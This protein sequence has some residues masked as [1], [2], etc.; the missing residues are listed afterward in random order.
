ML[1]SRSNTS[2]STA[3]VKR[4]TPP[5]PSK[6]KPSSISTSRNE[7]VPRRNVRGNQRGQTNGQIVGYP[8]DFPNHPYEWADA[9]ELTN[10]V[11]LPAVRPQTIGGTSIS[12]PHTQTPTYTVPYGAIPVGVSPY[13]VGT[14]MF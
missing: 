10:N 11:H 1:N 13:I 7:I 14:Q 8:E 12:I 4:L 9:V 5:P 2:T 6:S 3:I